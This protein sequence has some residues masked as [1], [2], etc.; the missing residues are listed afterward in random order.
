MEIDMNFVFRVRSRDRYF[1]SRKTKDGRRFDLG[2]WY[3]HVAKASH[4]WNISGIVDI[5]GRSFVI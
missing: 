2:T 3:L 1:G 4:F 5:R